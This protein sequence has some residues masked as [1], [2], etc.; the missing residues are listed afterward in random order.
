MTKERL[1]ERLDGGQYGS[2]VSLEDRGFAEQNGLIIVFGGSD[3]LMYFEGAERD[4][5]GAYNGGI[6]YFTEKGL[7]ANECEEDDCPYAEKERAKCKTITAIWCPPSGGSWAYETDIPHA[8]FKIYEDGGLYCTGIVF[9][10]A[11]LKGKKIQTDEVNIWKHRA[12]ELALAI[13]R[14]QIG[15]ST[16]SY[17]PLTDQEAEKLWAFLSADPSILGLIERMRAG[18]I[19]QKLDKLSH[20]HFWFAKD[21]ELGGVWNDEYREWLRRRKDD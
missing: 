12:E 19:R 17:K 14:A 4:E 2:E 21:A 13:N 11:S 1:A 18:D 15:V 7:F 3:D 8:T 10:I 5:I 16:A 20:Y 9:E 6:A